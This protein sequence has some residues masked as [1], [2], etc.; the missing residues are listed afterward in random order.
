MKRAKS[1]KLTH[2][3]PIRPVFKQLVPEPVA[4][5]VTRVSTDVGD[6]W[7][8]ASDRVMLP[9]FQNTGVWEPGEAKLLRSLLQPRSRFLDVGAN[10][11]YFS[12][13]AAQSSP[14]GTI[15]AVE[16]EPLNVA[17]LRMNLWTLAPHARLWPL[18]LGN[19]RGVV[20]LRLDE[21]NSGNTVA[22]YSDQAKALAAMV[23]G[24]ELFAGQTFDVVKIDVQ[25][26]EQQVMEGLATVLRQSVDVRVVVE[27]FP[28]AVTERGGD[29]AEVLRSY[30]SLGF[31]RCVALNGRLC[32]LEDTEILDL[33]ERS[34]PTGFVNLLLR[35]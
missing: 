16:P 33:C 24:D 22:E 5:D 26:F 10:V 32:R 21:N 11:G 27:F 6:L 4:R 31:E 20:A 35:H 15:D 17:L 18:C 25:G 13:L 34:G 9:Y 8:P 3:P 7:L 14:Q 12:A 1:E 2:L 28:V 19:S 23:R 30:R 29:P